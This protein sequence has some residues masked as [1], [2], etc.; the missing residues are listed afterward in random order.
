M[1][2][3]L[4]FSLL[5]ALLAGACEAPDAPGDSVRAGLPVQWAFKQ[6]KR[7]VWVVGEGV[8]ERL[9]RDDSKRPRHQRF[10]LRIATDQTVL[11]VHNI[12]L[13]PRVPL[14][15]GDS[16]TFRGEYVWNAQGGIVHQTH[17]DSHIRSAGGWVIWKGQF[18]R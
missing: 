6:E 16:V 11:I 15:L 4:V 18:F 5:F 10:V 13:A 2:R 14:G 7:D 17:R 3:S 9:L 8:V 1:R 12:D